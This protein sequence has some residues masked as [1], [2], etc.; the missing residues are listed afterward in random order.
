MEN[1]N[2]EWALLLS[3]Y[4]VVNSSFCFEQ[5]MLGSKNIFMVI[6]GRMPI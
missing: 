3:F 4:R 5:H 6:Y 2:E 1:V